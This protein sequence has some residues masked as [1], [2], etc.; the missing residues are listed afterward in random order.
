MQEVDINVLV[1]EFHNLNKNIL[2]NI[3]IIGKID[4]LNIAYKFKAVSFIIWE[5]ECELFSFIKLID[6]NLGN[7]IN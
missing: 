2:D 6:L 7:R 4:E 5:W 3:I 1:D